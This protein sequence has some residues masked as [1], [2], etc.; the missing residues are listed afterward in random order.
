MSR[1]YY[2][3]ILAN[4]GRPLYVGVTGHVFHRIAQHR[5]GI[6]SKFTSRYA[7]TRLAYIEVTARV[8]DAIRREK[9]IK[10]WSRAKKIALIEANNRAY[11]DLS[12]DWLE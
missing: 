12:A 1:S 10:R 4:R 8:I 5:A 9:K 2:V 6:A 7:I 11:N 3:Y